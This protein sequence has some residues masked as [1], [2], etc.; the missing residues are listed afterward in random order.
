MTASLLTW[1]ALGLRDFLERRDHELVVLIDKEPELDRH[2]SS[3]DVLITT[4]FWPAYITKKEFQT[5][6]T[7]GLF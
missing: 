7:L 6:Q 4:P 2:L 5:L 3:T 1:C